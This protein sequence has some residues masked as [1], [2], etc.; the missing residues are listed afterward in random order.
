MYFTTAKNNWAHII[1]NSTFKR[2]LVCGLVLLAALFI[3]FPFYFEY[4]QKRDGHTIKDAV[5][6]HLSPVNVSLPLFIIIWCCGLLMAVRAIQLPR[7]FLL[8][9]WAFLFLSLFRILCIWFVPLNPPAGIKNLTDPLLSNFYGK[10]VI[11]KDL[12]YS[13]H[14]ATIFLIFLCLQ[15]KADKLFAL[16]ATLSVGTMVLLQHVHYTIDVVAALPFAFLSYIIGR[17]I[18]GR[19]APAVVT[20]RQ[21]AV[22]E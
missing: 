12:F 17:K 19:Q 20:S 14:T 1:T 13:G 6:E 7:M 2:L 21:N 8:F 15:K 11:T 5:L 4:I 16:L 22:A 10:K 3:F 18:T 9:L